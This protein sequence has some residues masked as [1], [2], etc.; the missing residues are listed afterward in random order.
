MIDSDPQRAAQALDVIESVGTE[1]TQELARLLKLLK[2]HGEKANE[3]QQSPLPTLRDLEWL[4]KPVRSAGVHVDVKETG[5]AWKLDASVG[6]AAYRVVQE[7]LTNIAKHAGPGTNALIELQWEPDSL[8]LNISDDGSGK[9]ES[10]SAGGTGYGLIGLK[11]RVEI[12]G[13]SIKWG[14]RDSGFFLNAHL[15]S[16]P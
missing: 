15:P 14:P 1:A 10:P 13:G 16:S 6:H 3:E 2:L 7:S 11:A 9:S 4:L 12:A 8:T 5:Q